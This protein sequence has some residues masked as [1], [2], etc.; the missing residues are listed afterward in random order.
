MEPVDNKEKIVFILNNILLC[1]VLYLLLRI[2]FNSNS[3]GYYIFLSVILTYAIWSF[4]YLILL[5][6]AVIKDNKY[7][8]NQ[9]FNYNFGPEEA[10]DKPI[11][12]QEHLE[13]ETTLTEEPIIIDLN[14]NKK[15]SDTEIFSKNTEDS[16]EE[17]KISQI[18][19]E[20]IEDI[21]EKVNIL[22]SY[23][24][25]KGKKYFNNFRDF[26]S[27]P[28][29]RKLIEEGFLIKGTHK[30]LLEKKVVTELK[31]LARELGTKVSGRKDEIIN[32]LLSVPKTVLYSYINEEEIP[33]IVSEKG[34]KLLDKHQ[35]N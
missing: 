35:N 13:K 18:D 26:L 20:E 5:K 8:T 1:G 28:Q 27:D 11:L 12:D 21:T 10:E 4:S 17:V 30:D 23:L 3:L 2:F 24:P 7:R 32:N 29:F 14:N 31:N 34:L 6:E 22:E 16:F 33:Y 25:L 15:T 9:N 19:I